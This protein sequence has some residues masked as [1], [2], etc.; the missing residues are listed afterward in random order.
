MKADFPTLAEPWNIKIVFDWFPRRT[1]E[2]RSLMTRGQ[3]FLY[4][5]K[6]TI[7]KM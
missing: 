7:K 2:F 6:Y 3:I 1:D 5:N 4:T